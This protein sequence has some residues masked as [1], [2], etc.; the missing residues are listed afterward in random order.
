MRKFAVFCLAATISVWTVSLA[1]EPLVRTY[2]SYYYVDGTSAAVLSAQ[3]DQ[4]GP[5][6]SDGK[7]FAGETKWDIQWKFKHEQQGVT[8]A[9]KKV[10]VVVGIAQ[11][12]PKWRGEAK[13]TAA[14]KTRW[15]NFGEAL[16]RHEDRHKKHGLDAGR[17]IEAALLA[18]RPARNCEELGRTANAAAEGVERKYRQLDQE[19]DRDT[20][21]GRKQGAA[22]L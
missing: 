13:G 15:R 17:E 8:C 20:D 11:T 14:L 19:Y 22:L 18:V 9:M 10:A 16:T 2:T 12:M 21:H 5:A 6:G 7:R 4:N 1:A 3:I